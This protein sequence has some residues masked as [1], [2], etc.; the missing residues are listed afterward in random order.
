[1]DKKII[2]YKLKKNKLEEKINNFLKIK[3]ELYENEILNSN[4]NDLITSSVENFF[5]V[6]KQNNQ[7][8]PNNPNNLNNQ[9][10]IFIIVFGSYSVG[11]TTFI[12]HLENYI[13]ILEKITFNKTKT[14][15]VSKIF[16]KDDIEY[17]TKIQFNLLPEII[18]IECDINIVDKVN[19]LLQD[20]NIININIIPQ[21]KLSLKNKFINKIFFDLKNKS[22]EFVSFSTSLAYQENNI[23]ERINLLKLKKNILTIDDFSFLDTIV[24]LYYNDLINTSNN[25]NLLLDIH[26]FYL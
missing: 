21:N 24:D 14:N 18:I 4:N 17:L 11:K 16:V 13:G 5:N 23:N 6:L 20:K 22:N 10:Q 3:K 19:I 8:N 2:K 9:N 1:M 25:F 7:N 15:M 26:K 12:N